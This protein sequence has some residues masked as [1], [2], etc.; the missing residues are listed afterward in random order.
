MFLRKNISSEQYGVRVTY[1]R[2]IE[3]YIKEILISHGYVIMDSTQKEDKY[4]KI[5]GYITIDNIIQP[6]QIKYRETGND[7]VFEICF[8]DKNNQGLHW[9]G[10]DMRGKSAIYIC[11]SQKGD[12]I[13][14]CTT[15]QIKEK[16]KEM[17]SLLY[18][19]YCT[20]GTRSIR[21]EYG[22][23][24]ITVDHASKRTKM[25][26]F[27]KPSQFACTTLTISPLWK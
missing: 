26:F 1:G 9:N 7:I 11:L 23:V 17:G 20:N 22:E 8:I 19:T 21:N 25:L 2:K 24:K 6:M 3:S 16:A 12:E 10:R 5:D 18:Q 4:D 15:E 14:I 27:A 13:W